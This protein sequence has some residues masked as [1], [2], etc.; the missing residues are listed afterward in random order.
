MRELREYY[1]RMQEL[2]KEKGV[3]GNMRMEEIIN[4]ENE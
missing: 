3:V 4:G 1:I 2:M